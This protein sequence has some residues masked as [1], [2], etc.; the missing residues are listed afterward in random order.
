MHAFG[1]REVQEALATPTG[2]IVTP[3]FLVQVPV[4]DVLIEIIEPPVGA[5]V[6]ANNGVQ[7][8]LTKS[9]GGIAGVSWPES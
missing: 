4:P 8:P 2:T 5:G 6:V 1:I 7:P 9:L 3:E